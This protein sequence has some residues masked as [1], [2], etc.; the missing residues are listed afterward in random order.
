MNLYTYSPNIDHEFQKVQRCRFKVFLFKFFSFFVTTSP[1]SFFFLSIWI[2]T[3]LKSFLFL[4]R[5]Y[6]RSW[7]FFVFLNTS[8]SLN[9]KRRGVF[10]HTHTIEVSWQFKYEITSLQIKT[11]FHWAKS[12]WPSWDSSITQMNH[13]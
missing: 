12:H 11:L 5:T 4:L 13:V 10:S 7:V 8:N 2:R 6:L 3:Y 1:T 9:Y